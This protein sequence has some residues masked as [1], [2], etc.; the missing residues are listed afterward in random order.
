M[1]KKNQNQKK[2]KPSTTL[3]EKHTKLKSKNNKKKTNKQKRLGNTN[4]IFLSVY[5][6]DC[7]E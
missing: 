6:K 5:S 2:N 1:Q 3:K 7:A 4:L